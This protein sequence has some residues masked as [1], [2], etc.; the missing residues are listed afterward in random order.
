MESQNSN[1]DDYVQML[2]EEKE[3]E[4]IDQLLFENYGDSGSEYE[5]NEDELSD[6]MEILT[7]LGKRK[8]GPN[9]SVNRESK[10][11]VSET[12]DSCQST[13]TNADLNEE[14]LELVQEET[15]T[16]LSKDEIG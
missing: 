2:N 16:K 10:R 4:E 9:S 6:D 12:S 13:S 8:R 5:P 3:Q 7:E 14:L 1:Y 11:S 15:K